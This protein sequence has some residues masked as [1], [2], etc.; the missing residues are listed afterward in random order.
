MRPA[1]EDRSF[2]AV[3]RI[4][5]ERLYERHFDRVAGYVL[6]RTDR[7]DAGEALARTF[8][9][10]WRR[11]AEM[12]V[13]SLPWLLGVARRVLADSR[14]AERR[15]GALIER[16]EAHSRPLVETH[17]DAIGDR[18]AFLQALSELTPDQLEALLLTTWEGLSGKQAAAVLG[19]SRGA[20]A[21]RLHRARRR[22]RDVLEEPAAPAG[23]L[24]RMR[25]AKETT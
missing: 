18:Q 14:R 15:R 3:A 17:E 20:V 16:I 1:A 4:A 12:P 22:L 21:V 7:D 5:F 6:A 11:R 23:Q 2:D 24:P 10:A 25:S 13:D 9:I 19:C 8:E